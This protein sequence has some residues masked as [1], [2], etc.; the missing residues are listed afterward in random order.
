MEAVECA[1]IESSRLMG[2]SQFA[3]AKPILN[4]KFPSF[5]AVLTWRFA[6]KCTAIVGR[7]GQTR[8][9]DRTVKRGRHKPIHGRA[10]SISIVGRV[11]QKFAPTPLG[12]LGR[13]AASQLNQTQI[14][15]SRSKSL[16][17]VR[18]EALGIAVRPSLN[19]EDLPGRVDRVLCELLLH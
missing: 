18:F 15:A 2:D 5:A 7:L 6:G 14:A 4:K 11:E 12:V 1:Y 17:F 8:R 13:V 19:M 3:P 10:N 9:L 16:Q